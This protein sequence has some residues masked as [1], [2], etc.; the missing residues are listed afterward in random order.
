MKTW[1]NSLLKKGYK[2]IFVTC[3]S[4]FFEINAFGLFSEKKNKNKNKL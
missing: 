4:S 3:K 2:F 1:D